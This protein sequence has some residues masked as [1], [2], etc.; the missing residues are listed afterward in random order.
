MVAL[1][2]INPV[3]KKGKKGGGLFGSVLGGL[4]GAI[5]GAALAPVTGGASLAAT[6][7]GALGGLG[8]GTGLGSVVGEAIN[9]T[10]GGS[11]SPAI[12][13]TQS[14]KTPMTVMQDAPEVQYAT[15]QN[16]KD[17]LRTE[18]G[19]KQTEAENYLNILN[20]GQAKIKQRL[21]Y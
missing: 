10:K 3:E 15:I 16:A 11:V 21:G 1:Q 13:T 12:K 17:L 5:L 7:A 8:A 14:G 6:A 9:P 2:E 4:G 18:P 19:I 20:G